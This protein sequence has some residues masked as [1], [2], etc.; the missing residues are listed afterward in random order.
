M[1]VAVQAPGWIEPDPFPTYVTALTHGVVEKVL[2]LEGEPVT[3]GQ[4]VATLVP[5]DALLQAE[6]IKADLA[7]KQAA[8]T[9]AQT[10]WEHPVA[11]R[12][13]VAVSDARVQETQAE[14][15][16][17]DATIAQQQAKQ[18][19]LQATYDS[20][21]EL[22]AGAASR[23]EIE[24]AL[25]R[26][27]AQKAQVNATQKQR[28]VLDAKLARYRAEAE[29]AKED[30]RLRVL[31]KQALNEAKA[32]VKDAETALAEAELRLK[33]IKVTSPVAGVVMKR[34]KSPGDKVML[35][36]D[37]EH[38]AHVIHV[39]NP[40]KLQVRV[41]VP[42][43]DAAK[44]GVDQ[45]ARVI[46]DVL[47]DRAFIGRVTRLVHRADISKNTVQVKVAIEKP[48]AL[49]KPDMLAR[50]KFLA[51]SG[52]GN[53][54]ANKAATGAS[55][56]SAV[57]GPN[58]TVFVPKQAIRRGGNDD[59]AA[60]HAWVVMP[61]SNRLRR[62]AVTLGRTSHGD[63]VAVTQGLNP[64][65]ALVVDAAL[66]NGAAWQQ[67]MTVRIGEALSPPASIDASAQPQPSS[68]HAEVDDVID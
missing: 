60:S 52:G 48:S 13:A 24:T 18:Q 68:N 38:S 42:L 30:L 27:N 45:P 39:Y 65:D 41:D 40:K 6:R 44:V 25:H 57:S 4:V 26:L 49:L 66:P 29:A 11:L 31:Q 50:V 58:M 14:I 36:M 32:I 12:R 64:G 61:G 2:V 43:A 63:W 53:Q 59:G 54:S 55:S 21:R 34:L 9:A 3:A 17:L 10:D 35:D 33:R 5:D 46:V 51:T 15:A 7:R 62:Q 56:A 20:V 28:P 1:S 8:L 19:E 67:G 16:Q 47:P 37:S 22:S 23:L